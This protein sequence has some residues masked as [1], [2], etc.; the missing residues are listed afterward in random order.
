MCI[1]DSIYKVEAELRRLPEELEQRKQQLELMQNE[2][3]TRK[4]RLVELRGEIKEVEG[5]TSAQRMRL[6]KL[7]HECA[8]GKIDAAMLASYQHEM[9]SVK[10]TISRAEDDGLKMVEQTEALEKEI[11]EFQG[12]LDEEQTIFAEYEQNVANET[13]TAEARRAELQSQRGDIS[14]IDATTMDTYTRILNLR[15]GEALARLEGNICQG[16]FVGIPRNLSVRLARGSELVHCPSCN[17]I[18]F[19]D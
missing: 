7:D 16:C 14:N 18:L 4:H 3:N 10:R 8:S 17:R 19:S 1:R 11:A 12:R 5:H 9:K 15:E 2:I 13:A 6:R